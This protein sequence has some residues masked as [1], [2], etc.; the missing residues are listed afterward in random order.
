MLAKILL[1]CITWLCDEGDERLHHCLRRDSNARSIQFKAPWFCSPTFLDKKQAKIKA[2]TRR[3]ENY[4]S[5]RESI[6]NSL[7]SDSECFFRFT[8]LFSTIF[9]VRA[10]INSRTGPSATG[11]VL[12]FRP[13]PNACGDGDRRLHHCLRRDASE[14]F[15]SQHQNRPVCNGPCFVVPSATER[16]R[17]RRRP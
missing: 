16:L 3:S 9:S 17:R 11:F 6:R 7:R 10:G 15:A 4:G 12:S 8:P 2:C 1:F 13:L 14:G 5:F